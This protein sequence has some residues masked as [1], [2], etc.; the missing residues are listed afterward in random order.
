MP[1]VMLRQ[2]AC[3]SLLL[4][5]TLSL[6]GGRSAAQFSDTNPGLPGSL[7]GCVV[8]GD[9]DHDGDADVLVMGSGQHDTAY[10]TLYRNTGGVFSDSGIALLGLKPASTSPAQS[11][12]WAD[13]DGD[14]DLDL[15]LIGLTTGQ[16]PTTKVYRNDG[17]VFTSIGSFVGEY[18][19]SVSWA[20]YD[21]DG[22]PDLLVTGILSPSTNPPVAT[23]LYR[24][25]AGAFTPVTT[26][27]ADV[28]LGPVAWADV[29]GDGDLDVLLCG[30]AQNGS[31]SATLWLNT[32]GGT[33]VDANAGLPGL[34]L[35]FARFA[36]FDGDGD[37]DLLFG[38]NSNAGIVTRLYRNDGTAWTDLNA[39]L[40]PLVWSAGAWGDYDHDGT[41]DALVCGWDPVAGAPRTV[42]Y[43]GGAGLLVDS[44]MSFHDVY[45]PCASWLDADLDGDL[46][47]LL[48]GNEAGAD[49][50]RLYKNGLATGSTFCFGSAGAACPCANTALLGRGCAN[51][52]GSGAALNA[53]GSASLSNDTLVLSSSGELPSALSIFLQGTAQ[54]A[55]AVFGDGVRCVGGNLK[56]L[57][58]KNAVGGVASAP[59]GAEPSVSARCAVLND[60]LTAGAVRYVQTYYRDPN[61]AFCPAPQG[62]SFNISSGV[63]LTWAP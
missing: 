46:D 5:L 19:G 40:L 32:G 43:H 12:A 17:S 51:S 13:F 35:G 10:T 18:A 53:F 50:V 60:P 14:G 3:P 39:G 8:P 15:A 38:G 27:F 23:R 33:F 59:S 34:D 21:G 63:V 26:P 25:D 28:Y 56:R 62:S 20:D 4:A 58:T 41:L 29:D 11:A 22:D 24:N 37:P 2:R 55:A 61:A 30:V 45:L 36:D 52:S 9:Y 6:L 31:L 44:G 16:V 1:L 47:F 7:F 48:A 54:V 49:I 57:Y 42:L